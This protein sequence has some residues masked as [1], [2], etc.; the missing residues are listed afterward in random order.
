MKNSCL[1]DMLYFS[2]WLKRKKKEEK[3]RK[4]TYI[5][6]RREDNAW[7]QV[8]RRERGKD[9]EREIGVWEKKKE[10]RKTWSLIY[11]S[12]MIPVFYFSL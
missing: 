6:M 11:L 9:K 10:E 1:N 7:F 4:T 3:W 2:S 8:R 12:I 5:R